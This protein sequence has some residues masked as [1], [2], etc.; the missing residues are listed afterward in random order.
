MTAAQR[1][2]AASKAP[3]VWLQRALAAVHE[4]TQQ[5]T[6]ASPVPIGQ[7]SSRMHPRAAQLI[8]GLITYWKAQCARESNASSAKRT[9]ENIEA[10]IRAAKAEIDGLDTS[11]VGAE[12]SLPKTITGVEWRQIF[13]IP[14]GLAPAARSFENGF[15]ALCDTLQETAKLHIA[16][17]EMIINQP[18]RTVFGGPRRGLEPKEP[19]SPITMPS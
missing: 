19:T 17:A 14:Q 6:V 8:E 10:K 13:N 12:I 7:L 4:G 16:A 18:T 5:N 2:A 1:A 11:L 3:E 15:E 9:N